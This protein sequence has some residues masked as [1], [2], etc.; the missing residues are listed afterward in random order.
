M[1]DV[2]LSHRSANKELVR[3]LFSSKRFGDDLEAARDG[4]NRA[5][6]GDEGFA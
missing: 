6:V 3:L 1:R 5:R 2:S 4:I